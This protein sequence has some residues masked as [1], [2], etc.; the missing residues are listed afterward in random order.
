MSHLE[1]RPHGLH[2]VL[3]PLSGLV[4]NADGL[5]IHGSQLLMCLFSHVLG[6]QGGDILDQLFKGLPRDLFL[7]V[8]SVPPDLNVNLSVG[9]DHPLLELLLLHVVHGVYLKFLGDG[10]VR[11]IDVTYLVPVDELVLVCSQQAYIELGR[12]A[13]DTS[14]DLVWSLPITRHFGVIERVGCVLGRGNHD[15]VR[16]ES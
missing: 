10:Q 14:R 16:A 9:V 8:I 15:E 7:V 13:V 4:D 12:A 3:F 5:P 1:H 6:D 2:D 11:S